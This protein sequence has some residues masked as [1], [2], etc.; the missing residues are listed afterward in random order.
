MATETDKTVMWA[1]FLILSGFHRPMT[2]EETVRDIQECVA[3]I[4]ARTV[5]ERGDTFH[6]GLRV[7]VPYLR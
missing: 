6:N 3:R 1:M 2:L 7:D 4:G 5:A